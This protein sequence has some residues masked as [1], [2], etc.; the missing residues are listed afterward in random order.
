[1]ELHPT[2]AVIDLDGD[3]C[4]ATAEMLKEIPGVDVQ[5]ETQ[6]L[7]R[8]ISMV[9][10]LNP[11]VVIF[12][13]YPSE[14]AAMEYAQKINQYFPEC[15][16]V[17]S[18]RKMNSN[19][20]LSAMRVGAR[21]FIT[22]PINKDELVSAVKKILQ[23]K[24]D[25][26]PDSLLSSKM[27]TV[28]GV[29]GGAGATTVAT[30]LASLL[31]RHTKTCAVVIDLNF[32]FGDAA[33]LLNV[34]NRCS[35]LDVA[36]HIDRL[37]VS[38]LATLLPKT[39]DGV[40]LLSGPAKIEEAESITCGHLEQILMA[41]RSAFPYI[42]VDT[43]HALNDFTIKAM[44]ESDHVLMVATPDVP[45]IYN[46]TRCLDLFQKMGYDRE[47]VLL[48]L[49]RCN[50]V[51]ELDPSAVEKLLKYPVSWRFPKQDPNTMANAVN[52]G[53]PISKMLPNSK[54]SQN[55]LK[56]MQHLSGGTKSPVKRKKQTNPSLGFLH[57]IIK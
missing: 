38:L 15:A 6:D 26:S 47:K 2:I 42:I 4:I 35:V 56:M 18:A 24:K 41:V 57:R 22:Q 27:V 29:K 55:L 44:D 10:R 13:L 36:N 31:A 43:A 50:G 25:A 7:Y 20:V 5:T 16:L 11:A 3:S 33:L 46:T 8:G 37:D 21:E 40:S 49:N 34:K 32:Q 1:M 19:L 54:L 48:A 51:D 17:V 39:P 14:E 23:A 53:V 30:N 9:R 45:S 52:K 12:N 28:F